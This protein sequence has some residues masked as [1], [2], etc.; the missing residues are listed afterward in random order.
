MAA[1]AGG[2]GAGAANA[3]ANVAQ[4][5]ILVFD[6]DQ[7]LASEEYPFRTPRSILN[8]RI[9]KFIKLAKESPVPTTFIMY[10]N[11]DSVDYISSIDFLIGERITGIKQP[12]FDGIIYRSGRITYDAS[13]L[14]IVE[15]FQ[16]RSPAKS[17][18]LWRM[19]QAV[20][21]KIRSD[22]NKM[23]EILGKAP[24]DNI[25]FFDD[26]ATHHIINEIP[27]GHFIW[28]RPRFAGGVDRTNYGP[29]LIAVGHSSDTLNAYKTPSLFGGSKIIRKRNTHKLKSRKQKIRKTKAVKK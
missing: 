13:N 28:I 19:Y 4:E 15:D 9:L 20:P 3:V 26:L 29:A 10:T 8:E 14:P 2:G 1:A 12:F 6:L 11:N 18:K 5:V 7:T 22:I 25:Y 21:P 24:T 17:E 23:I 16:Y 27:A